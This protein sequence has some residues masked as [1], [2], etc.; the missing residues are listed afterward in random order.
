MLNEK[1]EEA[2]AILRQIEEE[3]DKLVEVQEHLLF[4]HPTEKEMELYGKVVDIRKNIKG[5]L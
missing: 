3:A 1:L 4:N 2:K 5:M